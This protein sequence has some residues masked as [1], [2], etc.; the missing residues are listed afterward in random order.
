WGAEALHLG[1]ITGSL[2]A[3]KRADLIVVDR[4]PLHNAPH[5]ERDPNS[6]YSQ[7]VYATQ[8]ADVQH[9]MVNGQWLMRDRCLLTLDDERIREQAAAYARQIDRF[10]IAREGN[11]LNKLVAIGGLQQEESFEIQVKVRLD[12]KA[13]IERLLQ[14]PAVEVVKHNH[15][16]QYD[17]Y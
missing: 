2:D 13:L 1:D 5:F 17:T 9:V 4:S 15:Y 3:G 11:V 6:V 14:N 16:R 8:S 10:L 7:L 12:D